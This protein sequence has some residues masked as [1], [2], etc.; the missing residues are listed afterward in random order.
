[1]AGLWN[2][3]VLHDAREALFGGRG[4]VRVW[5]LAP[6][7]IAPFAAVLACE[8]EATSSVGTHVQE[9]CD[10]I[11][12]AVEGEGSVE[13]SG[14]SERFSAGAVIELPV[15]ATLS[16]SNTSREEPLRYLIV[17]ASRSR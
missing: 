8:L 3:E 16:I 9:Y 1:M 15:G 6:S 11:V 10:E 14:R 4:T 5:D 17:K 12:I 7:P 2:R 13:V